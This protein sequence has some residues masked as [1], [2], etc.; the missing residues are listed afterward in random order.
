MTA[1][2]A[3]E[4]TITVSSDCAGRPTRRSLTAMRGQHPALVRRTVASSEIR[5]VAIG[6]TSAGFVGDAERHGDAAPR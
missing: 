5:R 1:D 4:A 2:T 3:T 6:L